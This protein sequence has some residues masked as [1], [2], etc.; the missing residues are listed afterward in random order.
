MQIDSGVV[1]KEIQPSYATILVGT[2]EHRIRPETIQ[3]E[4]NKKLK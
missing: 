1:L 2:E 3:N 4:L